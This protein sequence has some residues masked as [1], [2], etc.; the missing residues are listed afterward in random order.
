M[1]T[2][3]KTAPTLQLKPRLPVED[4]AVGRPLHPRHSEPP[5]AL[6]QPEEREDWLSQ[7]GLWALE[8]ATGAGWPPHLP[9]EGPHSRSPEEFSPCPVEK[10]FLISENIKARRRVGPAVLFGRIPVVQSRDS[11]Y[12]FTRCKQKYPNLPV[13]LDP[14]FSSESF[15][16]A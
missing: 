8:K 15:H 11:S 3:E 7:R 6:W 5:S 14:C 1:R 13:S 2:G 9:R 16:V 12:F 10:A 4:R